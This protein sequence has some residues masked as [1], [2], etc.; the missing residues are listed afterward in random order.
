[1]GTFVAPIISHRQFNLTGH[2]FIRKNGVQMQRISKASIAWDRVNHSAYFL[3]FILKNERKE[4]VFQ[5][6]WTQK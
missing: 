5:V 2:H 1:M 6:Q 4:N 3:L